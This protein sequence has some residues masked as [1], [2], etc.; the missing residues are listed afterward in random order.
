M[1]TTGN[2]V[3]QAEHAARNTRSWADLSNILFNPVD[4]LVAKA[5]PTREAREAFVRTGEY[6]RICQLLT[7]ARERHGLVEGG[8]PKK[9]G[10]FVVRLPQ[11]LHA[12]LEREAASEGVS[13]NQLVVAKLSVGLNRMTRLTGMPEVPA[14]MTVDYLEERVQRADPQ[15]ADRVLARVPDAP[16]IPGDEV[17]ERRGPLRKAAPKRSSHCGTHDSGRQDP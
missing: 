2:L 16:P 4:G 3:E 9:S 6:R 7:E 8:T 14:A 15:L 10:R 17:P 5:Y 13:L 11:S 12:A 1:K